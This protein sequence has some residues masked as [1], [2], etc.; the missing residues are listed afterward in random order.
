MKLQVDNVR[1]TAEE[2]A[3]VD[4]ILIFTGKTKENSEKLHSGP[5]SNRVPSEYTTQ[6]S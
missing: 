5:V 4:S 6:T 2:L 1:G 3:V